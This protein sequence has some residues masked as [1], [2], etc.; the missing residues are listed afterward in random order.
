MSKPAQTDLSVKERIQIE[1]DAHTRENPGQRLSVTEIC[2]RAGVSR[3][4]LYAAHPTLVRD[5]H[6]P[7]APAKKRVAAAP[8][9]VDQKDTV[10]WLKKRNQALLVLYIELQQ[11]VRLLRARLESAKKSK[12][13]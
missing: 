7:K 1:L 13:K 4:N 8:K 10:E 12:W 9:A 2:R 11:E 3:S 6:G 5:I